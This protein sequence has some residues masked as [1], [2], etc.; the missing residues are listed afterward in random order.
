[1]FIVVCFVCILFRNF[2]LYPH[3]F[4]DEFTYSKFSRL[5]PLSESTIS[6]YIYLL[7]YRVTNFCGD[8][9]LA[10]SRLLNLIF[11]AGGIFIVYKISLRY[12]TKIQSILVA[13]LALIGPYNT[14]TA[15]FM[16]ESLYF[17]GFWSYLWFLGLAT[18]KLS[19]ADSLKIGLMIGL[20]ALIKPHGLFLIIPTIFYFGYLNFFGDKKSVLIFLKAAVLIIF[21]SISIKILIGYLVAGPNGISLFGAIYSN[22]TFDFYKG[23]V[24]QASILEPGQIEDASAQVGV[25]RQSIFFTYAEKFSK[26]LGAFSLNLWGNLLALLLLFGFEAALIGSLFIRRSFYVNERG[27]PKN[28]AI[29]IILIIGS[30]MLVASVFS[31]FSTNFYGAEILRLQQRYFNFAYPMFFILVA[32]FL[33]PGVERITYLGSKAIAVLIA[34]TILWATFGGLAN[35]MPTAIDGPELRGLIENKWIFRVYGIASI[36]I[37]I[38]WCYI[39]VRSIKLY[40]YLFLPISALFSS[41]LV[42]QNLKQRS[43][44]DI[45]DRA[46]IIVRQILSKDDLTKLVVF[47]DNPIELSRVLF[48]LDI[49]DVRTIQIPGNSL[50]T[51]SQIPPKHFALVMDS[52]PISSDILNQRHYLG[53]DLV[54]GSGDI[55]I[56]FADSSSIAKHLSYVRGIYSPPE[57]WGAWSIDRNINFVFKEPLPEEFDLMMDVRAFAG[58]VGAN[59]FVEIGN[60]SFPFEVKKDFTS[61]KIRIINRLKLNHFN[62]KIPHPISPKEMG[63]GNDDRKL[64]IAIRSLEITW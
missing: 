57:L 24:G 54:G 41:V 19:F 60:S 22:T 52:H 23:L 55:K 47:G 26:L 35:Y 12:A 40:F 14:Y 1:M 39:P 29:Q 64:G 58:N 7:I 38:C 5:S 46:G 45:Y 32:S 37:L 15:Y 62:I 9:F 34:V 16:P 51:N 59:F 53:F 42:S 43:Q 4:S 20:C 48:Y 13:T 63:D 10:C 49:P 36:F 28:F 31:A 56:N 27:G 2:S 8:G 21:I 44:T 6:N 18:E 3:V 11:F 17:L 25:D 50:I 33:R 30:L 61:V